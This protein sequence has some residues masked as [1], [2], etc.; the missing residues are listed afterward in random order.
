M[1][2]LGIT[3]DD[4]TKY[5]LQKH[6]IKL[7]DIDV[8]RLKQIA[9]YEWFKDAKPW[10]RQFKM[11][12]KFNAKVEIQALSSK[13]ITFISDQYLPEKIKSREFLD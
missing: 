9:D 2:F 6:F 3:T 11:M 4:V 7:K 13:G 8:S 5:D 1:R 12:R 10:Q